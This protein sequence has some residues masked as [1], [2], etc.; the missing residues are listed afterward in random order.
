MK[1]FI[2]LILTAL[3]IAS[4]STEP[5]Y[6]I[7][8]K[9][10][11]AD[12]V[13][14][15]LQKRDGSNLVNLDSVL[16][17]QGSFKMTGTVKYPEMVLLVAENTR[18]RTSFYIENS[19]ITITGKLDSLFNASITGSKTQ[20]EYEN[21]VDS[22]RVLSQRYT[23]IYNEYQT[24][25]Q[26]GDTAR[27]SE[28][29][30]EADNIQKEMT[31]LQKNFVKNN[32]ASY[33]SPSILRSLSYDM[34]GSELESYINALDTAVANTPIVKDLKERAEKMKAVAV[35]QKAPDFT[36]DDPD[37]NP[38]SLYSKEGSK[39]LLIDFWAAWCGPCR[40]ENPNVVKV[41]N[42]FH[43]KGFDIFGVS[44][45]QSKD[46]WVKAIADDK[47]EWTQVSDL[48]YWNNAAAKLYAVNSIPANFL[49]DENGTI[50]AR[51]LRGEDLYTR[52]KEVL[53]N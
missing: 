20:D 3:L 40:R 22:N 34:D 9:I 35:G 5:H 33:V 23:T 32:P 19:K 7:N 2:N 8:G 28:L 43:K 10:E 16:A 53:G 18:M 21:F 48:Q 4:C 15:L 13:T 24:A 49:L 45:D 44:L 30:K 26:N 42:E 6:V 46:D 38:V 27:V 25:S 12:S 31:E 37:G 52:V 36:L 14:F 51:N 11:G 17:R 29:E 41:Y 47:L 39:L 50:L 1:N